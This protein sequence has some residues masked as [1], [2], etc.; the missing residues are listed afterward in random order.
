VRAELR[1]LLRELE[2]PTL[3][4]THDYADA[5]AL[6]DRIGVLIDGRLVQVG[7]PVELIAQPASP[8]VADFTGV[9]FLQ[10]AARSRAEGLTEVRLED[11]TVIVS[12]DPAEGPV[13]VVV[14]PW[15]IA[16]AREA[17]E[18]SALNHLRAPIASMV[19]IGHR[20]RVRVGAITAEVTAASAERLK[21]RLG[22]RVVATFKATGTRLVP[23]G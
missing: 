21:L 18:D 17:P 1:G 4:V 5:A 15:E 8:F 6:A 12:T 14:Y 2:L 10:G 9:N 20:M 7:T 22:E 13:G 23:L 16:I 19:P 3:M 11:G